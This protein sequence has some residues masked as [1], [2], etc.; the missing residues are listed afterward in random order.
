MVNEGTLS[1]SMARTVF[2]EMA[3]AGEAPAAI[4][5]RRELVQ[6]QDDDVLHAWAR[7][8]VAAHPAEA[9][10]WRAGESKL[11]G[12]FVGQVMKASGGKADPRRTN[13]LLRALLEV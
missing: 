9:E 13:E 2:A 6:V 4:V 8:A 11:M 3:E 7:A 1:T 10:R 12:F 5:E